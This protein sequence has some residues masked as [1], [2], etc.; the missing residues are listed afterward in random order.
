MAFDIFTHPNR[1][2][3]LQLAGTAFT[4]LASGWLGGCGA[5]G[6]AAPAV[7]TEVPLGLPPLDPAALLDDLERRS[8]NYF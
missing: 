5:P 6:G 8:F 7:E 2:R 4:G 3:W 1:R